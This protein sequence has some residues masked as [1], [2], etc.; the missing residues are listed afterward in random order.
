MTLPDGEICEGDWK[1]G[2]FVGEEK[3]EGLKEKY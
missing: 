2:V 1:D 3:P